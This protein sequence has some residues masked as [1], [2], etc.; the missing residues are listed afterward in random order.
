MG[1]KFLFFKSL[2]W[3]SLLEGL[4]T[5][6][7]TLEASKS[8]F[9]MYSNTPSRTLQVTQNLQRLNKVEDKVSELEKKK[10]QLQI[11]KWT[12]R[13]FLRVI[14]GGGWGLIVF[15]KWTDCSAEAQ[16]ER[17]TGKKKACWPSVCN[18]V[19]AKWEQHCE[20]S[21]QSLLLT[22]FMGK[23]CDMPG[24]RWKKKKK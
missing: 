10:E 6:I 13:G 21:A 15:F 2:N 7:V 1:W 18:T 20:T 22:L 12:C 19:V 9:L 11:W 23:A 8:L 14:L 4:L 16:T 3:L 24:G 17:G 5:W